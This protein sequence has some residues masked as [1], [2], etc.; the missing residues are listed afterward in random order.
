MS[1]WWRRLSAVLKARRVWIPSQIPREQV[2]RYLPLV[3]EVSRRRKLALR[4][5][6]PVVQEIQAMLFREDP[7]RVAFGPDDEYMPEAETITLWLRRAKHVDLDTVRRQVH[8][9]FVRW[10]GADVAGEPARYDSIAQAVLAIWQH[11]QA[12]DHW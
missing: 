1:S 8:E 5:Y 2:A 10:F 12:L 7:M 3:A 9:D 4:G 6:E 11:R